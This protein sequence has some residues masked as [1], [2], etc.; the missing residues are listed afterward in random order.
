[1]TPK[2]VVSDTDIFEET[3]QINQ[4][5]KINFIFEISPRNNY[6]HQDYKVAHVCNSIKTLA[7]IKK[8]N[9]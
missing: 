4:V 7:I 5:L 2:H 8:C 3:T 9:I 6:Y 1:M